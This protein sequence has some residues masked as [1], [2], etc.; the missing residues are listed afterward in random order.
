MRTRRRSTSRVVSASPRRRGGGGFR[1]AAAKK[2]KKKAAAATK[3][4][5]KRSAGGRRRRRVGGGGGGGGGRGGGGACSPKYRRRGKCLT[6]THRAQLGLSAATGAAAAAKCAPDDDLCLVM[7]RPASAARSR[8]LADAFIPARPANW[9]KNPNQW[10]TSDELDRALHQYAAACP[11]FH[12]TGFGFIDFAAADDDDAYVDEDDE[13][14]EGGG[15]GS[16]GNKKKKKRAASAATAASCVSPGMCGVDLAALSARGVTLVASVVN[17]SHH[18]KKGTHWT[19]VLLWLPPSAAAAAAAPP[20]MVYFDS[21]AAPTPREIGAEWFAKLAAQAAAVWPHAP[22]QFR[23]NT[24]ERQ[25][26]NTE[27]GM[28]AMYVIV[29]VA[30]GAWLGADANAASLDVAACANAQTVPRMLDE[31]LDPRTP[32]SDDIVEAY[33]HV[34]F[35]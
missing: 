22:L 17:L 33:R 10:L 5:K 29:S 11:A 34:L 26:T 18:R 7:S 6:P 13:D 9:A 14:D 1:A 21:N 27:C 25:R 32:L 35:R 23:A 2:K 3:K 31:L 19:T 24:V 12:Y 4:K 20:Q 15:K 8:V 30:R 16:S 28:F